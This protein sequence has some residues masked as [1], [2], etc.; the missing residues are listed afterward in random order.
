MSNSNFPV[1]CFYFQYKI[2]EFLRAEINLLRPLLEFNHFVASYLFRNNPEFADSICFSSKNSTN[3]H[4]FSP[5]CSFE[6]IILN[7]RLVLPRLPP[8]CANLNGNFNKIFI[9]YYAPRENVFSKTKT[10]PY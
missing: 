2:A 10:H 9:N 4:C 3:S 7:N 6:P 1:S 8:P 5:E